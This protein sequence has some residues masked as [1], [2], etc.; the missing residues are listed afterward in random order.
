MKLIT[1]ENQYLKKKEELLDNQSICK[2]NRKFFKEF[3]E[4]QEYKLKRFN[5]LRALD[6]SCYKTLYTYV[7][8]FNNVN[9]WFNN[10]PLKKITKKEFKKFYND[11]EDGKILTSY[12]KP[13]EDRRSY[14]NKIF[15]SK[16]FEMLGKTK[17]VKEVMEFHKDKP[18]DEVRF[19]PEEDVRKLISVII[20]P[21]H[22][23]LAWL[24]FDVGEN[25]NALLRLKKSDFVRQTEK[26][27]NI[28]EY[29]VN[30]RKETL[31]R[32]RKPRSEITNYKETVELLDIVLQGLNEN[33]SIFDFE[34]RNAKKFLDRA[35]RIT[36]VKCM[37]K[38][39]S[40][41]WKDLRS[42]MACDL[43][44]KNWSCDE[45]NAR[46]GHKPSS[47]EIDKYV[48]FLALDRHKPKRKIY[49]NNLSKIQG[50]LEK[51]QQNEKLQSMRIERM[52]KD[53]DIMKESIAQELTTE[54]LKK[55]KIE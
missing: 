11:F 4:K 1:W 19:I 34:Y 55:L 23:L 26:D 6:E 20:N 52:Q 7:I 35:V 14:Y 18:R 47:S 32:S 12:G 48:N 22:K 9:K 39:Q 8:R 41:T 33:D 21:R 36:G 16:P 5:G 46:L 49:E 24:S 50:E 28:P 29:R 17:I 51:T 31:K 54:I 10:K 42:S 30:L 13:F 27:T 44:K 38:G 3:F 37:P 43:L 15:K 25:V 53:M 45:V 40:V 2:E